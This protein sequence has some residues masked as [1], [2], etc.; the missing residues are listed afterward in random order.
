MKNIVYFLIIGLFSV[1]IPSAFATDFVDHKGYIPDWAKSKSDFN[2]QMTCIEVD[3]D[4][5]DFEWCAEFN[6]YTLDKM[7][8]TTQGITFVDYRGHIPSWANTMGQ[9]QA[10]ATCINQDWDSRDFE[11]CAEFNGY[12]LD[13]IMGS[14]NVTFKDTLGYIPDWANTMGQ[15]QASAT[16]LNVDYLSRDTEWCYEFSIYVLKKLSGEIDDTY[17]P[18]PTKE[19]SIP[20]PPPTQIPKTEVIDPL[21]KYLGDLDKINYGWNE[22]S[23]AHELSTDVPN[24]GISNFYARSYESTDGLDVFFVA[25]TEFNVESQV[26]AGSNSFIK[27]MKEKISGYSIS[28]REW[29]NADCEIVTSPNKST[30]AVSCTNQNF[31]ITTISIL[32]TDRDTDSFVEAILKSIDKEHP[33]KAK[34]FDKNTLSPSKEVSTIKSS[35]QIPSWVKNNAG[36]WADGSID[37]DAFVQGIK[38]MIE[39]K[40]I[41]GVSSAS[42]KIQSNQKV[43]DWVRNNAG[44]WADGLI[45]ED[46][47]RK[48]IQYLVES[49]IIYV[50]NDAPKYIFSEDHYK[51]VMM[52]NLE[53]ISLGDNVILTIVDPDLNKNPNMIEH[54]SLDKITVTSNGVKNIPLSDMN[55][56]YSN[57]LETGQ[58]TG[59]VQNVFEIGVE[60]FSVGDMIEFVYFDETLYI[61]DSDGHMSVSVKVVR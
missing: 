44:W 14:S 42:Q 31:L 13:K 47:F 55:P 5:R 51:G 23:D 18:P 4:S 59:I 54:L 16:C 12:V 40:I 10:S 61:H 36:W 38:F 56:Q 29:V 24:S 45:S 49:G 11:W 21:E 22:D 2:T 19:P 52:V 20:E 37:D 53:Q 26:E 60:K 57:F 46:D 39:E 6:G 8:G 28:N 43:P 7:T 32:K 17:T 41:D 35:S 1:A 48:G 9:N 30:T 50:E 33:S 27:T 15:N 25:I 34:I 58:N 3:W